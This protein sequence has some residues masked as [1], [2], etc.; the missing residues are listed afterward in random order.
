MYI[1]ILFII[2]ACSM[3][4]FTK[5]RLGVKRDELH[6]LS[7]YNLS[8][9]VHTYIYYVILFKLMLVPGE[10][11][12]GLVTTKLLPNDTYYSYIVYLL[13]FREVTLLTNL[14]LFMLTEIRKLVL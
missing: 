6:Y 8:L 5:Y 13:V 11:V 2:S 3:L 12:V 7:I 4:W 10:D 1:F 9:D 14:Q